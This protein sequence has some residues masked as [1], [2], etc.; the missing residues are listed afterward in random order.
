[1]P[2]QNHT[3]GT[4]PPAA[5]PRGCCPDL[6]PGWKPWPPCQRCSAGFGMHA[7][8]FAREDGV[9]AVVHLLRDALA[10]PGTRARS[11][12]LGVRRTRQL[13]NSYRQHLQAAMHRVK[14]PTA[15]MA[16]ACRMSARKMQVVVVTHAALGSMPQPT[17][18]EP[19]W[20]RAHRLMASL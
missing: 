3:A 15:A 8:L 18:G 16:S 6:P 13:T 9:G 20:G 1:M 14:S 4:P 10:Q 7:R 17:R 11:G 5:S 19:A 2:L 12:W